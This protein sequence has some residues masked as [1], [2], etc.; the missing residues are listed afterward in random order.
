MC[1]VAFYSFHSIFTLWYCTGRWLPNPLFSLSFYFSIYL[2]ICQSISNL[3]LPTNV[4]HVAS[5]GCC[6]DLSLNAATPFPYIGYCRWGGRGDRR[7]GFGEGGGSMVPEVTRKPNFQTH[8]PWHWHELPDIK[9]CSGVSLRA[10]MSRK[11]EG[12]GWR[13]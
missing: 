1:A 11:K 10:S 7:E 8:L 13:D 9:S 12:G 5:S 2:P 4:P 6:D 3:N